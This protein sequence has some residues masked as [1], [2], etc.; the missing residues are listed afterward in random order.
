MPA[1]FLILALAV[2]LQGC[3]SGVVSSDSY[4]DRTGKKTLFLSDHES[5]IASCND[6]DARCMDSD[7]ILV[8]GVNGPAG[9]FGTGAQCNTDLKACLSIC[10]N[11]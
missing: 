2:I 10:K 6:D 4:T 1:R 9:M 11:R 8:N 5:C 7:G 3:V